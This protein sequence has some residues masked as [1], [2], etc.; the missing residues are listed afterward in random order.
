MTT[1]SRCAWTS[2]NAFGMI[3][4]PP[5]CRCSICPTSRRS[6]TSST[7]SQRC[8]EV[9]LSLLK[10]ELITC[11]ATGDLPEQLRT[12]A[13]SSLCEDAREQREAP[14]QLQSVSAPP[15][16]SFRLADMPRP[17]LKTS[18]VSSSRSAS[19]VCS[20]ATVRELPPDHYISSLTFSSSRLLRNRLLPPLPHQVPRLRHRSRRLCFSRPSLPSLHRYRRRAGPQRSSPQEVAR[21]VE[22]QQQSVRR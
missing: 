18:T 8:A 3:S 7:R 1:L 6:P 22:C 11:H 4:H 15:S 16:A 17:Q 21:E 5:F 9:Q 2:F 12:I 13:V 10:S 14:S 20:T 19:S